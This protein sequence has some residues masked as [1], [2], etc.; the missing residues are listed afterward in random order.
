MDLPLESPFIRLSKTVEISLVAQPW[1]EIWG[2]KVEGGI[3][4]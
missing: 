4:S 3:F 2:S 1:P